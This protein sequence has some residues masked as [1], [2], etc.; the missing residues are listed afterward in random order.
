MDFSLS[1]AELAFR[2]EI[3]SWLRANVPAGYGTAAWPES[4]DLAGRLAASREWVERLHQGRWGAITWPAKYGGRDA[5]PME[6]FLFYEEMLAYRTPVPLTVIGIGMAGPTIMAYGTPAQQARHLE[7]I[8]SGEEIWCQGFSEPNAGSDLANLATRAVAHGD[9]YLVNGQKIWTSFGPVADWCLLLVRTDPVAAK[10]KGLS[11]LLVDMRSPGIEVRPIRQI[12]GESEFSELFFTDLKVPRENLLG[13]ENDGWRV[14]ITTLMHERANIAALVYTTFRRE[15][16]EVVALA[17]RLTRQGRPL[18]EDPLVRKRL[19]QCYA[20]AETM[21]LN[22]LRMR[23]GKTAADD[24]GPIG[25]IFKL[26]WATSNQAMQ[27]LAVELLGPD[28]ELLTGADAERG[29]EGAWLKRY[30]R[31]LANSIEGG[32][33]EILRNIVAERVLGMGRAPAPKAAGAG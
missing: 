23:V 25:S 10:H 29:A 2:D 8:V 13:R 33:S 24:P 14:A 22:N 26:I 16:R 31:S 9:H 6:Q 1:P 17:K 27:G 30:L 21:R 5:T 32:T 12:T 19:V 11:Y 15:L 4:S 3:R 7:K 18:S 20:I 28:A